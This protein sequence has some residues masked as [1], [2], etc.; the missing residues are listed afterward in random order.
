MTYKNKTLKEDILKIIEKYKKEN[1]EIF[2]QLSYN[3][4]DSYTEGFYDGTEITNEDENSLDN[5]IVFFKNCNIFCCIW[6]FGDVKFY[7]HVKFK[8]TCC[9]TSEGYE[10]EGGGEVEYEITEEGFNQIKY[11]ETN[12]FIKSLN[13]A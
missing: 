1:G 2:I 4:E 8:L 3:F 5:L 10:D 9:F 11:G 12:K 13:D 6:G 7:F